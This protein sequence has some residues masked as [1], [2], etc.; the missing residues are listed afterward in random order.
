M[1]RLFIGFLIQ[2]R[3]RMDDG[4]RRTGGQP[5]AHPGGLDRPPGEW[6]PSLLVTMRGAG[7][8]DRWHTKPAPQA[9]PKPD[10]PGGEIDAD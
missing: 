2:D 9:L 6:F 8:G 7:L 3:D 1:V 5:R 10:W 4:D